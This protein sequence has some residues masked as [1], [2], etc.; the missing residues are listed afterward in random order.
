MN[1]L[2]L[3]AR[4]IGSP[5]ILTLGEGF[6]NQGFAEGLPHRPTPIWPSAFVANGVLALVP[7]L[8]CSMPSGIR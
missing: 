3:K 2:D 8:N 4:V 6:I 7:K 1:F 5:L